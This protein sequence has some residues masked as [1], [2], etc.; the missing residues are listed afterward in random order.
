MKTNRLFVSAIAIALMALTSDCIA[1]STAGSSPNKNEA[2]PLGKPEQVMLVSRYH[3]GTYISASYSFRF[4]N[5]DLQQAN[6][7]WE[8]LFEARG[9]FEDYFQ[10]NTVADD[11]SFIFDLGKKT[12]HDIVSRCPADRKSRPL[13]WLGY[14]EANPSSLTP[15][16]TA[17][18][19]IGHCYL[20]YN[21]DENGRVVSLFHVSDHEKSKT[22]TINEIEVL[23]IL[24][25]K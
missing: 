9:D 12:C 18:V 25:R 2:G 20:T 4:L 5:Q 22:V 17:K 11:N 14:S 24:S 23:D 8:I 19:Q 10:V 15:A 3:G 7:N 16:T 6:N 21:N 1:Q 13:V